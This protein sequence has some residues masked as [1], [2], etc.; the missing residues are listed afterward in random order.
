MSSASTDVAYNN[1]T[2]TADIGDAAPNV[3]GGQYSLAALQAD[4][5]DGSGNPIPMPTTVYIPLMVD[6]PFVDSDLGTGTF[7]VVVGG[8]TLEPDDW[9]VTSSAAELL[10]RKS[11]FWLKKKDKMSW[12][13]NPAAVDVQIVFT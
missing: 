10:Q 7:K 9:V 6:F 1:T 5:V 3:L 2:Y 4:H 12:I 8:R 11:V 13:T